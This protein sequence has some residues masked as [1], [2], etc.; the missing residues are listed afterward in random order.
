MCCYSFDDSEHIL[1]R[2]LSQTTK[3]VNH[4]CACGHLQLI[5]KLNQ[6]QALE[7]QSTCWNRF[8]TPVQQSLQKVE[9]LN[10]FQEN[11]ILLRYTILV[12]SRS[13]WSRCVV[14]SPGRWSHS[15]SIYTGRSHLCHVTNS[16]SSRKRIQTSTKDKSKHWTELKN[17]R[18]SSP[19]FVF[20]FV[21]LINHFFNHH[22]LCY[23]L[24]DS[25]MSEDVLLPLDDDV[26]VLNKPADT[27]YYTYPPPHDHHPSDAQHRDYDF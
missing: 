14:I 16:G 12:W 2:H 17:Y 24:L 5:F 6:L 23:S 27:K 11:M 13:T 7:L 21:F 8:I 18:V 10:L 25:V 26:T 15:S 9:L 1:M 20:R 3:W 4:S 22:H 19:R